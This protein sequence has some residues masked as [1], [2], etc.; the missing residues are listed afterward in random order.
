MSFKVEPE[1]LRRFAGE[2]GDAQRVAEAAGSYL[3]NHG[4]LDFQAKG[5]ISWGTGQHASLM[6]DIAGLMGHLSE[7][8]TAS[9][10]ALRQS[11]DH[12]AKSD[13]ASEA[14]MDATYPPVTRPRPDF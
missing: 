4:D 1:A 6:A 13:L 3:K 7:L 5:L 2:V 14:K 10:A 8:G 9:D 11:A 12:Y